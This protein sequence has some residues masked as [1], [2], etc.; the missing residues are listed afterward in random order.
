MLT[1]TNLRRAKGAVKNKKRLG[2]GPGSGLGKTSGKGH[3]GQKARSGGGPAVGFEGGQMPLYRRLPKVGFRSPFPKKW[4][5]V[6]VDQLENLFEGQEVNPKTLKQRG[7][8]KSEKGLIK[9]LGNG[10]IKKSLKVQ[11][12][13]VSDGAKKKI[14]AAGGQVEVVN[15]G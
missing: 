12:H 9:I 13:R 2:R 3:K 1:L 4:Q 7:L 6:N 15:G 5:V 14:E 8:I 11:A 10:E